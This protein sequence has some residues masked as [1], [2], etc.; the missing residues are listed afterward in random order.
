MANFQVVGIGNAIVDVLAH[1]D[2]QLI[3]DLGI[4]KGAMSLVDADQSTAIY[5]KM[6]QSIECSGGSA[7]NTIAGIASLGG[8]AAFIGR[9]RDDQLGKVFTHDIRALG[10]EYTT[11]PATEGADTARCLVMVTPDA[12]RTM[13]T[14][15][16][17][18]IDLGPEDL[19]RE[20]IKSADIVYMEGYLWDPPRAKE[21][22]LVAMDI[23]HAAG[24]K[25]SFT[26]SDAFCVDRYRSDFLELAEKHIDILFANEVEIKSL[27]QTD[28]FDEALDRVKNHC[29]IAVLTR[30]EKGSVVISGSDIHEVPAEPVAKVVDTTGAGDLYAAGF[31]YGI[32]NGYN[33]ID[34]GRIGSIA[35]AEIISH[36]GARPAVDLAKLVKEKL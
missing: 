23:A 12:Q 7:A 6:G 17:A 32:T 3:L 24:N 20:L 30:S 21:A 31:L 13:C 10:V 26:L 33:L 4:S 25:V 14:Y 5:A 22:F 1:A 15:L 28:S 35:A 34:S 16:G 11:P 2:N 9:V 27:Y 8:K 18:S 36:I 19:D 29:E